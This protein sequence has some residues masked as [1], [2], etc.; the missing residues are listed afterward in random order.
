MKKQIVYVDLDGVVADFIG[1]I[2]KIYPK[3]KS[4]PEKTKQKVIDK[5]C[6]K[7]PNI[8]HTL[9][10]MNGAVESVKK[11]MLH[12]D[13]YFLSTPM[14][15]VP[16]SYTAKRHWVE[17]KF[18]L[19]AKKKLILTHR[20]DLAIGD[21]LIDDRLKNGVEGFKGKHIHFGQAPFETWDKVL[22]YFKI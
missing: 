11:L 10:E 14:W 16:E 9:P 12:Y 21:F 8:F 4:V 2:E 15:D 22:K 13:V 5:L 19:A 17:E 6:E 7:N 18:G 3:L 20:K 1:G